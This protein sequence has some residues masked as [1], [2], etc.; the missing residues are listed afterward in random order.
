MGKPEAQRIKDAKAEVLEPIRPPDTPGLRRHDPATMPKRSAKKPNGLT[1]KQ[2]L[3]VQYITQGHSQ[4]DAYRKAY[5]TENMTDASIYNASWELMRHPK[6]SE[7]IIQ[8]N[9][10]IDE[11]QRMHAVGMVGFVQEKLL[12]LATSDKSPDHVRV[13]SLELLGRSAGMFTDKKEI[14]TI[15]DDSLPELEA[16][17]RQRMDALRLI[18]DK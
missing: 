5:N 15:S 10:W 16:K 7:R 4:A 12:E 6:V 14:K 2:D 18:S 8:I 13:K 9:N 11:K 17:L 1:D 3:F